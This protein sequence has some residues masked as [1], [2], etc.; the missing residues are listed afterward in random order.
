MS[1]CRAVARCT[2]WSVA[3]D[4]TGFQLYVDRE[5]KRRAVRVNPGGYAIATDDVLLSTVLGSC[6][7]VCLYDATARVGGM[8]HFMLPGDGGAGRPESLSSLYGVNAMELLINGMLK[9][10]ASKPRLRAKLFGAGC[11][12]ASLSDARIGERNV[13]FVRAYLEA[14]AIRTVGSDLLGVHPRRVCYFP[15]SG[16]ALC[17]RLMS[18]GE[19]KAV[20][21]SERAYDGDLAKRMA[22]AGSLELF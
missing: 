2:G 1:I 8:N 9:Q 19:S 18:E 7:S 17:K 6:V 16:R 13:S 4:G 20:G 5:F 12:M 15:L 10:G 3:I 11:V 21:A 22:D 14:E